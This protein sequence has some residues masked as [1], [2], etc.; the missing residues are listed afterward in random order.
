MAGNAPLCSASAEC[1]TIDQCM[2]ERQHGPSAFGLS[3]HCRS[4]APMAATLQ[5]SS[6][7]SARPDSKS[8]ASATVLFAGV[9]RSS[10]AEIPADVP[11]AP[12]ALAR[13]RLVKALAF[14]FGGGGLHRALDA[15]GSRSG[16][17]LPGAFPHRSRRLRR[18][19]RLRFCARSFWTYARELSHMG[20]PGCP[21]ASSTVIFPLLA[22]RATSRALIVSRSFSGVGGSVME[23][24]R[25]VPSLGCASFSLS[26]P[27]AIGAVLPSPPGGSRRC[28]R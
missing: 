7:T 13:L 5:A 10:A 15:R 2:A 26:S 18:S 21:L 8:S 28:R 1:K 14:L 24:G 16:T 20:S 23:K 9:S 17:R 4:V 19:S 6:R 27:A 22:T 3:N 12:R 25:M 11:V